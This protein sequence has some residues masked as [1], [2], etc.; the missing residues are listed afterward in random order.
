MREGIDRVEAL[1][2]TPSG[3]SVKTVLR[4]ELGVSPGIDVHILDDEVARL[5]QARAEEKARSLAANLPRATKHAASEIGDDV[6][7]AVTA[8]LAAEFD[9]LN[10]ESRTR[11]ADLETDLR[12]ARQRNKDLEAQTAKKDA[13]IAKLEGENHELLKQATAKDA[14]IAALKADIVQQS[15]E[16]TLEAQMVAILRDVISNNGLEPRDGDL[17]AAE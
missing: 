13:E 11:E 7:R 6:A 3:A 4:D 15:R 16:N 10:K 2:Q 5:C 12:I 8:V 9:H 1:G 17:K 14:M